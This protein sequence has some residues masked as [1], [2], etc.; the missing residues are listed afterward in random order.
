MHQA[1]LLTHLCRLSA[2]RK[3]SGLPLCP[4][5]AG[6]PRNH[7]EGKQVGAASRWGASYWTQISI[8]F[9]RAVKTRRFDSLSTQDIVQFVIV[10]LL[11]GARQLL[12]VHCPNMLLPASLP[13]STYEPY[14]QC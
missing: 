1:C 10:G 3:V 13:V 8:L 11:S 6:K 9:L 5:Q 12:P 4:G 2:L 14:V 7:A